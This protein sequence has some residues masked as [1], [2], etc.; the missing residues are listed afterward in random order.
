MKQEK[1]R[2]LEFVDEGKANENKLLIVIFAMSHVQ[3]CERKTNMGY[4]HRLIKSLREIMTAEE[5]A[6]IVK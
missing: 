2:V 3:E 1:L 4:G 5:V 6:E